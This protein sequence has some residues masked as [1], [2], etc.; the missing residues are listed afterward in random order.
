MRWHSTREKFGSAVIGLHWLTFVLVFAAY[1]SMELRG[2]LP[3]GSSFRTDLKALHFSL[4]LSVLLLVVVRLAVRWSA[5]AAPPIRPALS[6][7]QQRMGHL[8]HGA[9]YIFLFAMPI[10]GWFTLSASGAPILLFGASLPA[11]IP[12]DEA[13]GK[14]IKAWHE[15]LATFGY[16]LIGLHALTALGHHYLRHDNTLLRMLAFGRSRSAKS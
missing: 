13:L 10:L 14:Q 12:P 2:W 16:F 7:L 5:G 6:V 3:K 1:V 8:A 15:A 9:L 4:G 11:L